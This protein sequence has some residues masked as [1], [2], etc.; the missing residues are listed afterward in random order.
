MTRNLDSLTVDNVAELINTQGVDVV[1][2]VAAS[3]PSHVV[4]L[5]ER[6]LRQRDELDNAERLL[7]LERD[8]NTELLQALNELTLQSAVNRRHQ[9]SELA[10]DMLRQAGAL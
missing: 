1:E 5:A 2:H 9:R 4:D 7:R 3:H 8:R 10:L 6:Y